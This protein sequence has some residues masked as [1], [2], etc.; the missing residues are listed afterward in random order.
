MPIIIFSNLSCS[1]FAFFHHSSILID[2]FFFFSNLR[3]FVFLVSMILEPNNIFFNNES[4]PAGFFIIFG[5]FVTF[6][7]SQFYISI[8]SLTIALVFD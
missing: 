5:T 4:L 2:S 6:N 1:S 3:I 7:V 8:S